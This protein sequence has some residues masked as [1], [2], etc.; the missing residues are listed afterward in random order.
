M[1]RSHDSV[2]RVARGISIW[3]SAALV[4]ALAACGS[5]SAG[6]AKGP[7]P[8]FKIGQPYKISGRWYYPEFVT[9][10]EATGVASW[11]GSSYHGRLTANGEVYDMYALT[12]A[13]P[14]LQ[15][16]SVVEVVNLENGR[17]L[18]LRVNDRGPFVDDRLIDL[19]LAAARALGFERQGL[20]QVQ[21]R[22]LG[23]AR[24]DEAPIRPGERRQYAAMSC[25][26]PEP[27]R[28]VC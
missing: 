13:H 9:E 5:D 21:V 1:A 6:P 16:P 25:Q 14:T 18:V 4:L 26:L 7:G 10:Y 28:L 3:W 15:L 19:S 17:S 11:Y 8:H 20:A 22:Y 12:A 2:C 24:L 27:E 23:L